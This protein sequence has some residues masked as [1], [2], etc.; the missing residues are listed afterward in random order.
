MGRPPRDTTEPD[1]QLIS[2]EMKRKSVTLLLL[3]C[4]S[5][6]KADPRLSSI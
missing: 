6:L 3:W 4:Q 1:W 5:A 2:R